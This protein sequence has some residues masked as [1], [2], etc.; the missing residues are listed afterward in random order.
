M[1]LFD[2]APAGA[3]S[4]F[5]SQQLAAIVESSGDAIISQTLDGVI[6]SW[7]RAA[8]RM[9][10]YS[11]GEAIGRAI[12]LIVPPDR[13]AEERLVLA[14]VRTG[15]TVE[16]ETVRQHRNGTAVAVSLILSPVRDVEG[17]IVGVSKIARDITQRKEAEAALRRLS[18]R[19]FTLE[20]EERRRLSRELHDSTAQRLAALRLNL[21]VVTEGSRGLDE[22]AQRCLA[23]SVTLTDECLREIRTVSYLLHP[24]EL[25]ELGLPA[26]IR[27][28]VEGFVQRSGVKVETDLPSAPGRLSPAVETAVF[29]IVQECLTNIHRHSGSRTAR[30]S[31][32]RDASALV[33]DVQDAGTGL[34]HD[35]A[36]GVGI[37][38]M[39]ERLAQVGGSLEIR[40][41][42]V[43]THVHA[44]IPVSDAA[45]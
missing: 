28:Y 12:T 22:R 45:A 25:G 19:F 44:V 21:S 34:R 3:D 30:I 20:E 36:P 11:A 24:P 29:R 13:R 8:E 17:D 23:E 35:A 9:F 31:L 38:S 16:M 40:P 39:Q 6:T 10:G 5:R 14:R 27:R 1:K 32:R 43:G 7:N 18:N 33:L 15:A 2:P 42:P 37:R 4:L 41:Q 26:A